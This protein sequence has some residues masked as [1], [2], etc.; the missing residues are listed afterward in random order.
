MKACR[1][2]LLAQPERMREILAEYDAAQNAK[3]KIEIDNNRRNEALARLPSAEQELVMF[4][5]MVW[6]R[7]DNLQ[8]EYDYDQIRAAIWTFRDLDNWNRQIETDNRVGS[9]AIRIRLTCKWLNEYLMRHDPRRENPMR[10]I[11]GLIQWLSKLMELA[12]EAECKWPPYPSA[13]AEW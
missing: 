3:A 12:P 13:E 10:R 2:Q 9:R 4:G 5:R 1:D 11:L 6:P 7:L 8:G